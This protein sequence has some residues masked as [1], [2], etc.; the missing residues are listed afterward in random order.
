MPS[1]ENVQFPVTKH[2][3]ESGYV[4]TVV[5]IVTTVIIKNLGI[6]PQVRKLATGET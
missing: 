6:T 5:N 2:G 4:L 3:R 1:N